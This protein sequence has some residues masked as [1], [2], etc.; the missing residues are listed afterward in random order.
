MLQTSK[1]LAIL[2]Y[3]LNWFKFLNNFKNMRRFLK[4]ASIYASIV[5]TAIGMADYLE[6]RKVLGGFKEEMTDKI[7]SLTNDLATEQINNTALKTKIETKILE[8]QNSTNKVGNIFS[9][10]NQEKDKNSEAFEALKLKAHEEFG[11][12]SETIDEIN[13]SLNDNS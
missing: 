5:G 7:T 11:K 13:K 4:E 9:D 1:Y 6:K 12:I 3:K 2:Y 10:L 8:L